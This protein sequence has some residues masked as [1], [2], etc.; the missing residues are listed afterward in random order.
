MRRLPVLTAAV[1]V[2]A[3]PASARAD[4]VVTA[5]TVWRFDASTY[6]MAQGEGLAFHND[7]QRSPGPHNVTAMTN[8]P[9]GKPLFASQSIPKD[10][11]TAVDGAKALPPGR[12]GFE[13]TVHPFMQATLVV[14]D[15]ASAAAPPA[16]DTTAP[17]VR[18]ALRTTSVRGAL[19]T[20]RIF[21]AVTSSEA[22]TLRLTAVAHGVTIARAKATD[23]APG[24]AVREPLALTAAGR[25]VLRRAQRLTVTLRVAAADDAGNA[26]SAHARRTLK[27]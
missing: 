21:A 25:R 7:D 5:E 23:A 11:T 6:T 24:R 1:A 4:K 12:Y 3:V 14:T 20:G 13:C 16:K 8:G 27:R 9:D 17:T 10:Q 19:A 18:A 15:A 26:A 22:A 2:L